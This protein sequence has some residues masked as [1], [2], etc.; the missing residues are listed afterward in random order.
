MRA[1]HFHMRYQ[2]TVPHKQSEGGIKFKK[3]K[4]RERKDRKKKRKSEDRKKK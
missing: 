1:S 4:V 2:K 3:N